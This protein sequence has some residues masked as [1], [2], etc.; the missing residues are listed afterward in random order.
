MRTRP[1]IEVTQLFLNLH[2]VYS[3]L[4]LPRVRRTS[5]AAAGAQLWLDYTPTLL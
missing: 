4:T 2:V 5:Q 3:L 1:A